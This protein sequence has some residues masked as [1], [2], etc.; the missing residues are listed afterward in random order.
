ML[1]NPPALRAQRDA[2]PTQHQCGHLAVTGY[3]LSG[4]V[5]SGPASLDVETGIAGRGWTAQGPENSHGRGPHLGWFLFLVG[6]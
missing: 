1:P 3:S 4:E 5:T 2:G 6:S